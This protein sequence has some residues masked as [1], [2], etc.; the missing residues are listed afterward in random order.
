MALT[1]KSMMFFMMAFTEFF[2]LVNPISTMLN[3]AFMK[4][5]STAAMHIQT[6]SRFA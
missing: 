4:K 5:T 3:P 6:M 1:E 2:P